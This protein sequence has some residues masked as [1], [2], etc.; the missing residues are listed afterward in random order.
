MPV[1]MNFYTDIRG[2]HIDIEFFYRFRQFLIASAQNQ[3]RFAVVSLLYFKTL[4]G[5][6][7]GDDDSLICPFT[8]DV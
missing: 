1:D 3:I 5:S 6:L 7:L 4:K 8:D 2:D